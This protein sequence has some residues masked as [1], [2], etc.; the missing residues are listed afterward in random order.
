M[1]QA[2]LN[3]SVRKSGN[4]VRVVVTTLDGVRRFTINRK[5]SARGTYTG[6]MRA[7]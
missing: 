3:V 2:Q 4:R 7:A 6:R 1:N 5:L